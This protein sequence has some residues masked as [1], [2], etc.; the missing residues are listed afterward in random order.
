VGTSKV[1][2]QKKRVR[3]GIP[4][5]SLLPSLETRDLSDELKK[6]LH[7]F[8]RTA[9]VKVKNK[10]E[11]ERNELARRKD[12]ENYRNPLARKKRVLKITARPASRE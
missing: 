10:E 4:Q 7:D 3:R 9:D 12:A 11:Q 2:R 5:W 8:R 6:C 1:E